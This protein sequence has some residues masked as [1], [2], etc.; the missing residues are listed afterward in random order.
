M[1][2]YQWWSSPPQRIQR[3]FL[4]RF[5]INLGSIPLRASSFEEWSFPLSFFSERSFP[6]PFLPFFFSTLLPEVWGARGL[7]LEFPF[8]DFLSE[9][10]RSLRS[11]FL[12]RN[13][14]S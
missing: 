4:V 7:G 10:C 12:S 11:A 8:F 13:R 3:P 1:Y 6:F 9:G 14:S 5:S 2:L